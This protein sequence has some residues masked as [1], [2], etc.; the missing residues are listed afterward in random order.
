MGDVLFILIQSCCYCVACFTHI[1]F[2]AVVALYHVYAVLCVLSC[3]HL[4][5]EN[6][7][8]VVIVYPF[9]IFKDST[10]HCFLG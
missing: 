1:L 8:V 7:V 9:R 3:V 10:S 6:V 4:A 5:F 2:P